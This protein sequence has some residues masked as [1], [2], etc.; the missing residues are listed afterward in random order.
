[1][2]YSAASIGGYESVDG[3]FVRLERD[4]DPIIGHS[5]VVNQ[6]FSEGIVRLTLITCQLVLIF[7]VRLVWSTFY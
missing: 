3:K 4:H 2:S 7:I 1:M 6:V 5:D